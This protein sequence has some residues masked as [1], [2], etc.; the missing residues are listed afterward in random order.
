M[1]APVA[2]EIRRL[3]DLID[4]VEATERDK[5]KTVFDYVDHKGFRKTGA[6]LEGMPGVALDVGRD[7]DPIWL[8]V[9]RLKKKAPPAAEDAELAVWLIYRDDPKSEPRLKT[10][11]AGAV[12]VEAGLIPAEDAPERLALDDFPERAM[13]ELLFD[14][15]R[16]NAWANWVETESPRR[17]TIALYN[18]LFM[19]RQQLE[20]I[21]DVPL[22]LA[23][24]IG[25]ATLHRD[26]KRLRY[27]LLTV[28]QEIGLNEITHAIEVRPRM[29]A[30][31]A[32]EVDPLDKLGL[33]AL[34]HWRTATDKFLRELED[35]SLSPF[36]PET[37]Q[38]P[39]RQAAA[40]FNPDAVYVPD[41]DQARARAIPTIEP[42]LQISEAFAFF[43]RER[44]A[45]ELMED[46]RRFRDLLRDDGETPELPPAIAALL[47][48]P[49]AAVS[50]E[51]Y[52]QFRGIS[53]IPGVTSSTGEGKD[54]FFPLP[55]NREQV[56]VVQRL[57]VRPGVVVQGPPGTGKTHTIAN[58]ISHYLAL[59]KRVLVTSQKAP[60]LKVLRDKLPEAV[61]PLAVSL[62]E[63]DRDGLKQFQESVDIIAEKL[64]RLRRHELQ[65]EIAG[66]DEQIDRL[67][68]QLALIDT[69]VDEIGWTAIASI[70]LD[71][72]TYEPVRAAQLVVSSPE[73]TA[74]LPDD[75]DTSASCDPQFSASDIA[76]L[77]TARK[78]V[79]ADLL[80]LNA[81]LPALERLPTVETILD[82]HKSLSEAE[83]IRQSISSGKLPALREESANSA[84][85]LQT[86]QEKLKSLFD[87]ER[88]ISSAP[89]EWTDE[90]IA[91]LQVSGDDDRLGALERLRP[92]AELLSKEY[93]HFLTRPV[94]LPDECLSDDKFLAAIERQAE[95]KAGVGLVAGIFASKLKAQLGQV[96][97]LGEPPS[98]AEDW[99]DVVRYVAARAAVRRFA[100]AWNN[101]A[102]GGIGDRLQKQNLATAQSAK[103]QYD[104]IA[105]TKALLAQRQ[106]LKAIVKSTFISTDLLQDG[107]QQS[108]RKLL[109]AV[110]SHLQRYRLAESERLRSALRSELD[111]CEYEISAEL[112]NLVCAQLGSP[113]LRPEAL[114]KSWDGL[115]TRLREIQTKRDDLVQI[116]EAADLVEMSGAPKWANQLRTMPVVGVEDPLLP[117]D[118]ETR[119]RLR[120]LEGWLE[121]NDQHH[122][123]RSLGIDR[124]EKEVLLKQAYARSIELR[125][126]L[127]LSNKAS[128]G[129]KAAL[130]A[131]AD[132][133][134]RIGRGTGKRAGRYRRQARE[135]SD[136]AKGALPCWIMPHYRVSESLPADLGLFDLVIVDEASQSTVAAL[137]ALL[138]A[139][140]I[141]IV[142]DD[143]QVS[144][145][146]VGRDQTRADELANRHLAEQ[147]AD[148]RASLR[149][150]Q[151]L[152]DLGKVVF[153]G[154][155]IML[156]EH[157]RC[158]APIIEFS[159]SQFYQS[160]NPLRLPKASER[161]DPPLIDVRIEDGYRSGDVNPPEAAYIVEE[162]ARIASDPAMAIRTIG[163]T[164]LL[165]QKQAAHIY[166]LIEQELG[167]E[168][169]EQHQLR[170]G[171]PTAFQGDER[172]IIF[173]S[174]VAQ[175][176]DTPLSGVRFDQRF[177]VATSRARDRAYLVRSVDSAQLRVSDKLRRAL[178]DHFRV[179][180]PAEG[181][182][183]K[184]RREK[185]ESPFET[186]MYD[187]L[188]AQGYRVDTQVKVGD[189]RI[190]LVVEGENDRR[191]AIE[192]DGDRFHGPDR[193]AADM[194]RQRILERAGWTVWR[195]FASRFVRYQDQVMAELTAF[196]AER[197]IEPSGRSDEWVSRHTEL[198]RW[199]TPDDED[200][201]NLNEV[202]RDAEPIKTS[203]ESLP[204]HDDEPTRE[205]AAELPR[206]TEAQVQEQILSL[207]SDGRTWSNAA[208]KQTLPE[209]LPLSSAD[210]ERAT[211][212]PQEEKWEELVNNALSPSRS[213]S[214]YSRGLVESQGRGSHRLVSQSDQCEPKSRQDQSRR[215]SEASYF[216]PPHEV[217]Q[218]YHFADISVP[219]GEGDLL[220]EQAH[221]G[222]L[223]AL[224]EQ[225]IEREGPIYLDLLVERIARAH[226][227]QKAG[228]IIQERVFSAIPS[229]CSQALDGERVVLFPKQTDPQIIVPLRPSKSSWRSHRDIPLIELAS[230]AL[231]G[232][233]S[234]KSSEEILVHYAKAFKLERL[235]QPTRTRFE[236]AIAI[237]R[238]AIDQA[239]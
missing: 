150:E 137:P 141:L 108:L 197:G 149:E 103:R 171:D 168:I 26:G 81:K 5:L 67:H 17:D 43:Q 3:I 114:A 42:Q 35:D 209:R 161:L 136:R 217:G 105:A 159:K 80:Y 18:A 225:V 51:E 36:A 154:G 20:G 184:N 109:E 145:D 238:S 194:A 62:L 146:F 53:S 187:L 132:A 202:P 223:T 34:D 158:V 38:Q 64:Q 165:G 231:P 15:W 6:E 212:R 188:I 23:C 71:G 207:M 177:N 222:R 70:D 157:F 2:P 131:Y 201:R 8:R 107:G 215:S 59:G 133:M 164:T 204:Q 31:P 239:D 166:S 30:D 49:A 172:D 85:Q 214:L 100:S 55:F 1:H 192:C 139:K 130:A 95:G 115:I 88:R 83:L 179:P 128:D 45:T 235:R 156:T 102:A 219:E 237:A 63:S 178:L 96:T 211:F 120:R 160:L 27:P 40:Q 126:W 21:S 10:E 169:I 92:D 79:G 118:W 90:L 220:Y 110:E 203:G 77:R 41:H 7:D 189:F 121:T 147:V 167:P 44:R 24:G 48:E 47:V 205:A 125:T 4:Y 39:L 173:I 143:K 16:K 186:E 182:T 60:A 191:V 119:W 54:L 12:L 175:A 33:A 56:E 176:N 58:I 151:S 82:A 72:D 216:L 57:E 106:Q 84:A 144:P 22:E 226:G 50:E 148:Y 74:W 122:R 199:R 99:G 28:A 210:R 32:L 66:L 200:E 170:V 196:L 52:P 233:R 142:G 69:E 127:E 185:C 97:V 138:R 25:F 14:D 11:V 37:Y 13:V 193:W 153:A 218:E 87:E 112:R 76:K 232:V 75:L 213:N 73:L 93:Q 98:N 117:G 140:T 198:R 135:A 224:V 89:Y 91:C 78:S 181:E 113:D 155:A 234:K 221:Q 236:Q 228:R 195:C 68:R 229:E 46:L 206:V 183:A 29:E 129:V 65:N 174:L 61:R 111:G 123:L 94:D 162:I 227:K 134:R 208:L 190:D 163:V 101:V 152:Y 180:F 124:A 9:D 116:A 104:H 230:L 86:L 19:L